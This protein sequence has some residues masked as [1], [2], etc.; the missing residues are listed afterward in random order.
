MA[1]PWEET[2]AAPP[3]SDR[4]PIPEGVHAPDPAGGAP[5]DGRYLPP[6]PPGPVESGL[7]SMNDAFSFGLWDKLRGVLPGAA[8]DEAARTAAGKAENPGAGLV[9][10]VVGTMPSAAFISSRVGQLAPALG[11]TTIGSTAAREAVTGATLPAIDDVARGN[12]PD[13]GRIIG[14][15]L[16][17]GIGGTL[18]QSMTSLFPGSRF[19]NAG[20]DLT[21]ADKNAM[22]RNS[23]RIPVVPTPADGNPASRTGVPLTIPELAR[24]AAPGRAAG[25]E[26]AYESASSRPAG[27]V[28]RRNYEDVREQRLSDT[29][30][31]VRDSM[32]QNPNGTGLPTQR[33]GELAIKNAD[34]L[35]G[36]S[37]RPFYDAS[38]RD[39]ISGNDPAMRTPAYREARHDIANDPVMTG[40]IRR[41]RLPVNSIGALDMVR[42]Q[43][44]RN[45]DLAQATSSQS[46]RIVPLTR[47]KNLL[48]EAMDYA[49]P[50]YATGRGIED[51]GKALLTDRLNAGPLGKV[52]ASTDPST[53]AK[54][55]LSVSNPAQ[56]D[57]AIN[58][59]KR[60][61]AVEANTQG[62]RTAARDL[63]NTDV[64]APTSLMRQRV[65]DATANPREFGR[66]VV[67]DAHSE[68][69]IREVLP[70]AQADALVGVGQAARNVAPEAATARAAD[71][72]SH[73]HSILYHKIAGIGSGRL[74]DLFQDPANIPML[75]QQGPVRGMLNAGTV[76][77]LSK[78]TEPADT[79][80]EAIY[81]KRKK[82]S[83]IER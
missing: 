39:I 46:P 4:V 56:A 48:T 26:G 17:G 9:G 32:G 33:A 5:W 25:V 60:L 70:P 61:R 40:E 31:A 7:R 67:P 8:K 52:A 66:D 44:G 58:A 6:E 12:E 42:K 80:D 1:N 34:D 53:Q 41:E 30:Q 27:S 78:M 69:V 63:R 62:T 28:A 13:P 49:S 65:D 38:R 47:D 10:S 43:M 2:Y 29:V 37:S 14:G 79:I 68:R 76:A 73:P 24:E 23:N 19:R 74:T 16:L 18:M 82:R 64:D 81:G 83:V 50:N 45:L 75:G 77:G 71:N 57:E 21:E 15:G 35:V 36:N 54:G 3:K 51:A 59:V 72:A 20:A 55:L 11:R 22:M